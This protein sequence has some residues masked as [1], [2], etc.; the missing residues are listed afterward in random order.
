MIQSF[1]ISFLGQPPTNDYEA[2]VYILGFCMVIF[3]LKGIF[4]VLRSLTNFSYDD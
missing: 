2:L 1:L 3:I 4:G